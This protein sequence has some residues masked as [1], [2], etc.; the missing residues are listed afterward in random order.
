MWG[1]IDGVT[2]NTGGM[3]G[4]II[5]LVVTSDTEGTAYMT[6]K[7]EPLGFYVPS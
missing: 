6:M 5:T 2:Y 7:G 4:V 3:Y 1:A